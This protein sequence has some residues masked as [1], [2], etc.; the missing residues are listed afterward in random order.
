MQ[1]VKKTVKVSSLIPYWL[2]E[3]EEVREGVQGVGM[4]KGSVRGM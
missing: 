4:A 1:T 3:D 2:T